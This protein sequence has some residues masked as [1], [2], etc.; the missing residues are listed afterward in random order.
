MLEYDGLSIG[1]QI[2]ARVVFGESQIAHFIAL[3]GDTA[4]FHIDDE[5]ARRFGFSGRIVH[6]LLVQSPLSLLLGKELPGPR[7]V[8]N[9]IATKFHAPTYVGDEVEYSLRVTSL[10]PAVRA[11]SL[12]FEGRTQQQLVI[13]GTAMCT[14]VQQLDG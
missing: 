14:F 8:I 10:S 13:S 12:G 3:T 11:V 5:V 1:D 9:T 2:Q 4:V 6:G 7:T